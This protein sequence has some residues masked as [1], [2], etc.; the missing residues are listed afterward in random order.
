MMQ[1]ASRWILTTGVLLLLVFAAGPVLP[2]DESPAPAP[3]SDQ[4]LAADENMSLERLDE[5]LRK[6]DENMV[7]QNSTWQ[8]HFGERALLVVT[9]EKADRMRIMA[10]I[11]EAGVLNEGLMLRILQANFDSALDARYAVA[12]GLIWSTFVHPLA[13]LQDDELIS[14]IFQVSTAADNFGTSFSSGIF[15][16]GGGDSEK[17]N[18]RLLEELQKRLNPVT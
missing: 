9:D 18:R 3:D 15:I 1:H 13:A 8:I 16:Y 10:P 2:Q 11:A 6:V 7:R 5:L 14:A 17:E 12:K 4:P